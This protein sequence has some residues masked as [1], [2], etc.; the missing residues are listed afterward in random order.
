MRRK[1]KRYMLLLERTKN[2]RERG[3]EHEKEKRREKK[4]QIRVEF[5]GRFF[6]VLQNSKRYR[7][8][9]FLTLTK[10]GM[11]MKLSDWVENSFL[12]KRVSV[13]PNVK[14]GETRLNF[15]SNHFFS[16]IFF[17]ALLTDTHSYIKKISRFVTFSRGILK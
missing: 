11:R 15:F 7:N 16:L 4:K 17:T 5:G 13:F 8:K 14:D 6:R 12:E 3:G 2:D 1:R 10:L 9:F